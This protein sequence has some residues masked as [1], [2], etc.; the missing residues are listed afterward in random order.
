GPLLAKPRGDGLAWARVGER[1]GPTDLAPQLR[2][3]DSAHPGRRLR[4][5][6]LGNLS[7]AP[8]GGRGQ[9]PRPVSPPSADWRRRHGRGLSGGAPT[10]EAPLRPEAHPAGPRG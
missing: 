1:R 5:R 4:V 10:A 2:C 7:A 6:S 3:D 8:A 9:A